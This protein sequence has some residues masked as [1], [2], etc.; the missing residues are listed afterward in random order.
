MGIKLLIYLDCIHTGIYYN[1]F[2]KKFYK[3]AAYDK[4]TKRFVY[5]TKNA[6]S[7]EE[8]IEILAPIYYVKK[9]CHGKKVHSITTKY[10]KKCKQ[11]RDLKQEYVSVLKNKSAIKLSTYASICKENTRLQKIIDDKQLIIECYL[12]RINHLEYELQD[13]NIMLMV[14]DKMYSWRK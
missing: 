3:N 4:T 5:S 12:K 2:T 6:C 14:S 8:V 11:L 10:R 13:A 1:F 7:I 9:Y